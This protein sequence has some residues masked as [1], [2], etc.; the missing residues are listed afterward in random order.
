MTHWLGF[1]SCAQDWI[2]NDEHDPWRPRNDP[3]VLNKSP[4]SALWAWK[5]S[6]ALML[7]QNENLKHTL[8]FL[9]HLL[10]LKCIILTRELQMPWIKADSF[11]K[12]SAA[13]PSQPKTQTPQPQ[14]KSNV[15]CGC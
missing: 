4:L 9:M 7:K 15:G 8:F 5:M 1:S 14:L 11:T 12:A 13:N 10:L 3:V 6:L 2:Y